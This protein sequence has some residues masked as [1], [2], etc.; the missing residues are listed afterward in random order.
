MKISELT[1]ALANYPEAGIRFRLP[2]GKLVPAHAHVT[3]AARVD[4]NFIDC[5]GTFRK[6]SM[7][8]LQTWVHDDLDHR[9]KAGK[10]LR[11]LDKA[12]DVL[13]ADD[14]P[15]DIEHELTYISQFPLESVEVEGDD[16]VFVLS[17][18]HT[19]CLAME[20]CCPPEKESLVSFRPLT[21]QLKK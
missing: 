7:C 20:L 8:R 3:E 4:K 18:R 21:F 5:G 19:A 2:D 12:K 16:L 13:L 10:L 14:L 9:L 17:V 6:D 1:Q 15:V 11:I